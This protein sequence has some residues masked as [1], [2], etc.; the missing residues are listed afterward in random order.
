LLKLFE[1]SQ[2]ENDYEHWIQ[3]RRVYQWDEKP[4]FFN[5]DPV[6]IPKYPFFEHI[7]NSL[8]QQQQQ[9]QQQ[10]PLNLS[11]YYHPPLAKYPDWER[12]GFGYKSE[13]DP[14]IALCLT[15]QEKAKQESPSSPSV[16]FPHVQLE[17]DWKELMKKSIQQLHTKYQTNIPQEYHYLS[18][19]LIWISMDLSNH[20]SHQSSANSVSNTAT[21]TATAT[22]VTTSSTCASAP[23]LNTTLLNDEIFT[24]RRRLNT[25]TNGNNS[26]N[27][28][29]EEKEMSKATAVTV[30]DTI[31]TTTTTTETRIQELDQYLLQLYQT[32]PMHSKLIVIPQKSI[33]QLRKL[34]AKKI[35]KRW[36]TANAMKKKQKIAM[37]TKVKVSTGNN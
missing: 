28:I 33:L 19:D 24:K 31:K 26:N 20:L 32:L 10:Q 27:I 14:I 25:N 4:F 36:E 12:E 7:A 17:T 37:P 34:I 22:S 30:T 21:A 6:I 13:A 23:S 16:I 18:K 5:Y 9:S 2:Q 35:R 1:H 29:I 3:R 8:K 15:I 11:L